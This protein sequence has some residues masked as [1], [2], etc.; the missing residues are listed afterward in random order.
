MIY[1]EQGGR[2]AVPQLIERL[3]GAQER[4]LHDPDGAPMLASGRAQISI[5]H[6]RNFCAVMVHPALRCGVD[7]E[8]PRPEQLARVQIKFLTP[9]ELDARIDLLTAWTAKE[10]VFKAAGNPRLSLTA[11]DTL[12]R[13]GFALTPSN[14]V[15]SL[16]TII[17]PQ[18]TLT[19]ALPC[20]EP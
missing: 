7:I 4:V 14:G 12:S 11:I 1:V 15:F 9:R 3:F 10:A 2:A 5:S 20:L 13:P 17:T 6:S 19:S 16:H 18:F 8:Q